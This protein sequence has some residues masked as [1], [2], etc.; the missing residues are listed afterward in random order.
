[1][2]EGSPQ[3]GGQAHHPYC[4][5]DQA[6]SNSQQRRSPVAVARHLNRHTI[7]YFRSIL[8]GPSIPCV[9]CNPRVLPMA[10]SE[11]I[12]VWEQSR[13][14]WEMQSGKPSQKLFSHEYGLSIFDAETIVTPWLAVS[15][16]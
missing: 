2:S 4:S 12:L 9:I 6:G 15:I 1:M 5:T 3:T 8:L 16:N 13:L 11:H 14:K 10:A 7:S